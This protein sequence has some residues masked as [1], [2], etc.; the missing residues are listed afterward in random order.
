M[1]T[2]AFGRN[3]RRRPAERGE[4]HQW[5]LHWRL[6]LGGAGGGIGGGIGE[7]RFDLLLASQLVPQLRQVFAVCL[8]S[9]CAL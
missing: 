8:T 6:R 2:R 7:C 5:R 4:V 9:P 1:K 3:A